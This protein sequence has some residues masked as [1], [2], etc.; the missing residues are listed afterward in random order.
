MA[1]LPEG[2]QFTVAGP[3]PLLAAELERAL[4][5]YNMAAT[6]VTEEIGFSVQTRTADGELIGGVTGWIWGYTSGMS[7]VWVADAHQGQGWATRLITAAEEEAR[8]HGCRRM[9]VSSFTFQAP[10]LY[11]RIGYQ[12]IAR[13]PGLLADGVE[14]VWFVKQLD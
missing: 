13:V 10:D 5:A 3:D 12:E 2:F 7:M 1:D 6:G 11:R 4:T 14:D 8:T 9:F